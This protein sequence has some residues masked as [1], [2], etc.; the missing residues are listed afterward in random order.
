MNNIS[1]FHFH[2]SIDRDDSINGSKTQSQATT[3]SN[4]PENTVR[5]ENMG[6]K[7]ANYHIENNEVVLESKF[8]LV[9]VVPINEESNEYLCLTEGVRE[10]EVI[11]QA[12]ALAQNEN[13]EPEY[14]LQVLMN[15]MVCVK[16]GN[17]EL[18]IKNFK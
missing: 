4:T 7:A 13:S 1:H 12:I 14:M 10:S 2:S 11:K 16:H 5:L 8:S 18:P 3:E 9:V 17:C 6:Q 15:L